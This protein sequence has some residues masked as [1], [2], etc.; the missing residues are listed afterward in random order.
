MSS[1]K[2]LN[3]ADI[4]TVP[5]AA[6][7]QW[8]LPSS[9]PSV[10]N[11]YFNIYNGT[12]ITGT[13]SLNNYAADPITNGQYERLVYN[14]IN[15]LFY[16]AYSGSLLDTS[17]LMFNLNTYQSASQ[18]RPTGAYFDYNINPNLVKNFPTGAGASIK[19]LAVNQ[20]I[21]GSKILPSSFRLSSSVYNIKDDGNGNLKNTIDCI[22]Y[23]ATKRSTFLSQDSVSYTDCSGVAQSFTVENPSSTYPE[24]VTFF[25]R[26]GSV[27][28]NDS[29]I[30]L[31]ENYNSNNDNHIGNVFYAHGLAIITNPDYQGMF[32]SPPVAVDNIATF[33]T[34]NTSVKTINILQNDIS[35][36]CALD[37]G[38]VILSGSNSQYYTVN[39]NGTI[40]LN[41]SSSGNYDV[42]YTVNSLCGNGCSLTSN[43]AKVEV[44]VIAVNPPPCVTVEFYG[45]RPTQNFWFVECGT[46]TT[47]SLS[48]TDTDNPIQRC[49]D[50]TFGVS[51]SSLYS[52]IGDC[53]PVTSSCRNYTISN[54]SGTTISYSYTDCSNIEISGSLTDNFSIS[55]CAIEDSVITTDQPGTTI[56]DNA[57][58]TSCATYDLAGSIIA[59]ETFLYVTCSG[60]PVT[61][62]GVNSTGVTRCID[63]SYGVYML[64]G[65]GTINFNSPSC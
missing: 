46:T 51:G 45:G 22:N 12:F 59:T 20:E 64:T 55:F 10:S 49:I 14:S 60:L 40:T 39:A 6:N 25:A 28:Y 3:K 21:Y 26:S 36:S 30:E 19:V 33:L 37:T 61:E 48:L 54:G 11:S 7:K 31:V 38:S 52:Y 8:V 13:F 29:Q 42:Y 17:S 50:G 27:I 2:K 65:S 23:T 58:C 62:S 15:H 41:V 47:S 16:Q 53:F 4:T 32:P 5:Y 18:Q 1:F 44:N 63:P 56:T 43:K 34:S 57:T 35:R 9:C 24:S